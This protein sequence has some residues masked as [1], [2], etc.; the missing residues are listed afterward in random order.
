MEIDTYLPAN[1]REI[2]SM[3][4]TTDLGVLVVGPPLTEA[5]GVLVLTLSFANSDERRVVSFSIFFV[6]SVG[7]ADISVELC[8]STFM[9]PS[10]LPSGEY[11][12]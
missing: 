10:L 11:R 8:S 7:F 9:C 5:D 1:V 3:V 4:S 12:L 6:F 2:E